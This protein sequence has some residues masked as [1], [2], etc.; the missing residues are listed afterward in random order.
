[1]DY[2]FPQCRREAAIKVRSPA[3]EGD[4]EVKKRKREEGGT[5]M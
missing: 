4:G 1:M 2:I 3:V 5:V